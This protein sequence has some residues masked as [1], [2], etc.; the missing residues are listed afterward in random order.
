MDTYISQI[1]TYIDSLIHHVYI[2]YAFDIY[3]YTSVKPFEVSSRVEVR[4]SPNVTVFYPKACRCDFVLNQWLNVLSSDLEMYLVRK[5]TGIPHF[6]G[7][8]VSWDGITTAQFPR[9]DDANC[10]VGI[11]GQKRCKLKKIK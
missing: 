7:R 3:T 5:A 6:H 4:Y 8:M 10:H 1:D 9:I 2:L 11:K